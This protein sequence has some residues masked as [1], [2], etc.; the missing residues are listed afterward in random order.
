MREDMPA[1]K[2]QCHRGT[3]GGNLAESTVR[4]FFACLCVYTCVA[5]PTT[6][7]TRTLY[8][9]TL[10]PLPATVFFAEDITYNV[11]SILL[12]SQ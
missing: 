2:S 12:Y 8:Q 11:V 7:K 4:F 10:G 1:K 3:G 5:L 9:K 6:R